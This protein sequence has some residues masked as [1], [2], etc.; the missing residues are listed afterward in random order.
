VLGGLQARSIVRIVKICPTYIE[1]AQLWYNPCS[2]VYDWSDQQGED[3][4][5]WPQTSLEMVIRQDEN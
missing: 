4:D 1:L 2:F 3:D 5:G